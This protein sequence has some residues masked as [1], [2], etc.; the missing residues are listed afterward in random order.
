MPNPHRL[1]WAKIR[2]TIVAVSAI[3]VLSVLT[4]LLSGGTWLKAKVNVTTYIPDSTGLEPDADVLLNG[5]KIGLVASVHLSPSKDPN[6]VVAVRMKI[7]DAFLPYIPDDSVTTIDSA[8]LLGDKYININMGRSPEH[9]RAEGELRFPPPSNF[10]QNIDL[11]QFD[12][13]LRTID[14]IIQ[15][16]QAGKG[17][18]GQFVTSDDLYHQFLDGVAKVEK[19]MRAA[20][21]SQSQLGQALYT[22][23]MHDKLI[24]SLQ[25]LDNRLAQ[26]QANPILRDTTQYD[27]MREQIAKVRQTLADLNAGKGAGGQL[28][29]SDSAYVEWNRRVAAFIENVDALNS[30][31]GAIGQMLSN[32]QLYESV[33]GALQ[34]LHS[35]MKEFHEDPQ[36][37]LRIKIF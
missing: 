22:S 9:V 32:A 5:V 29:A 16:I 27:Q 8:N 13:Q 1:R 24:A 36:K 21:G 35:T 23:T 33:N 28:I 37:F 17:P 3:A 7:E 2:I 10:M 12:A 26:L 20:T 25:Q 15:D 18:L 30:G 4:Y 6:R 34:Q 19:K 31:E 11:R 14:Q